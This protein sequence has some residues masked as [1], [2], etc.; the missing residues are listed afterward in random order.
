[1]GLLFTKYLQI[2]VPFMR[3]SLYNIDNTRMEPGGDFYE[4]DI[5]N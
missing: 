4:K 5:G 1:M 2:L 3:R